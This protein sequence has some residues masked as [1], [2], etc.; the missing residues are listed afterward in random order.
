[1]PFLAPLAIPLISA[2]VS[3]GAGALV[4]SL[5]SGSQSKP[6]QV[7]TPN[8][9]NQQQTNQAQD[10]TNSGLAQQQQLVNQL[11][12]QN[13]IS[14]QNSVYGQQ[15]QL[16][17]QL[18]QMAQGAGP[19]PALDQLNQTTGQN[20][21]NQAA[22]M[23]GQRGAG[24][25]TG[26]IARQAAQQ[27]AATQQQ[28]VGQAATQR[29]QQQLNA[30]GALQNQQGMLGNT[31][32]QQVNNQANAVSN[33][34]QFAQNN[35]NQ[36]F[37]Q[38]QNQNQLAVGQQQG[39]NNIQNQQGMQNSGRVAQIAGGIASGVAPGIASAL[40]PS[41]QTSGIPQGATRT[42]QD[43]GPSRP[44]GSFAE[45]GQVPNLKENYSSYKG[46]S[47][48]GRLLMAEGGMAMQSGGHVPGTAKVDGAKD[49]YANDIVD[50]KLSPGEFVIPRH[51]TQSKD[52]R[53][54]KAMALIKALTDK[55][56]SK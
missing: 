20:V 9:V 29:S 53:A 42:S 7:N 23:A 1:M 50:A 16:A 49:S 56:A 14:N 33:L 28:A 39:V 24:S 19:N 11:G 4:N 55:K 13:G 26:L 45:G 52:P 5:S 37:N 48:I 36:L 44:D 15:Q 51:V 25:N 21:A 31:A 41:F 43:V 30:I 47:H 17:N 40:S 38:L 54:I 10:V 6:Q 35:Q 22:L 18:G 34:N 3:G 27:G 46:S 2:A 8:A 12:S 32:G